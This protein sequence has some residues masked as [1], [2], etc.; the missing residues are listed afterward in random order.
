MKLKPREICV[1]ARD[2]AAADTT[3]LEIADAVLSASERERRDRFGRREDRRD[4]SLAH[5]LLRLSL[6]RELD[7]SAGDLQ[8]CSDTRGRSRL[9]Q[10][11]TELTFSLSHTR[12]LVAAAISTEAAVGVD[13]E[14][15]DAAV[16]HEAIARRHFSAREAMALTRCVDDD[17]RRQRFF[18]IWTLKEAFL[19]ASGV[20][21]SG[22]PDSA[23]FEFTD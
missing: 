4:Y 5:A 17:A 7:T 18:E 15:I 8:F 14:R 6:S 3:S 20:G 23:S 13:V 19:K 11:V 12:G 10:P 21:L 1:W 16:D 9:I 22:L 2:T